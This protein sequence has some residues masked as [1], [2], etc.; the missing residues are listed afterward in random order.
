MSS[1]QPAN[2]RAAT[3]TGV[4]P[5]ETVLSEEHQLNAPSD[6]SSTELGMDTDDKLFFF[7]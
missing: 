6:I 1:G 4:T 2:A 3:L 5:I 7:F